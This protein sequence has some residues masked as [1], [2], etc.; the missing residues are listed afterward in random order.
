MTV[1][2]ARAFLTGAGIAFTESSPNAK[3]PHYIVTE[4]DGWQATLYFDESYDVIAQI[5]LQSPTVADETDAL[6][7]VERTAAPYGAPTETP[8]T[9]RNARVTLEI[10]L[11]ASRD[12][13]GKTTWTVFADWARSK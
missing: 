2:E 9:W 3:R 6:A 10:D 8:H 11:H 4:L 1:E 7:I 13:D 12:T 5:L